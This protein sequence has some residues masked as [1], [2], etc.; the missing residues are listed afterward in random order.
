MSVQD[1]IKQLVEEH[2]VVL[3]MKGTRGAPQCGFSARV[4]DILDEYL[5]EYTTVDV[6]SDANLRE[7]VKAFSSWP[8]IPQLYVR[9]KFVGGSDIVHEMVKS[10]E[11]AQ[12][13]GKG[14]IDLEPPKV[15]ITAPARAAFLRFWESDGDTEEPVVRLTIGSDWEPL[16]DLDEERDGDVAIDFEELALVMTRSTARRANGLVVDF[17][18]R[19]G[20][21]G[22]KVENPNR[23]ARAAGAPG[24]KEQPANVKQLSVG[25]LKEWRERDKPHLL[26]DVRTPEERE[27][28]KIEG[29]FLLDDAMRGK[30][31]GMD[32]SKTV[33][34]HCHHG[35]RSQRAAEH[36]VKMGFRDVYNLAGGIDAWSQ[37]VDPSVKRY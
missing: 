33:V 18:E 4:V 29:A 27:T 30:L 17:V 22:F 9:A 5:D 21:A 3:F 32:R 24:S 16:L 35:G 10:G 25:E 14:P 11:L 26:L 8:T 7:G 37:H 36:L 6:L 12:I 13:L 15:T 34:L 23:P 19:G 31:E 20:Q 28:A 2:D 1:R